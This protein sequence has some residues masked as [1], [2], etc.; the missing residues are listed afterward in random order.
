MSKFYYKIESDVSG[1]RVC[2]GAIALIDTCIIPNQEELVLVES[3]SGF[4]EV[5]KFDISN[6]TWVIGKVINVSVVGCY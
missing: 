2:K 5:S 3:E 6:A 1:T 4:Q